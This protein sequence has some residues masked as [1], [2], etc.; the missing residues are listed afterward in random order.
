LSEAADSRMVFIRGGHSLEQQAPLE[1][2]A[3]DRMA[4]AWMSR[5]VGGDAPET[6]PEAWSE[7]PGD[8]GGSTDG[9]TRRS[10]DIPEVTYWR[11]QDGAFATADALPDAAAG[12]ARTLA[13]STTA[14]GGTTDLVGG[15]APGSSSEV[16]FPR[17]DDYAPGTF[18]D[19][20]YPVEAETEL[21]GV[22][23]LSLTVT[24]L[25]S[26]PRVFAK[27]YHVGSDGSAELIYNQATAYEIEGAV[28]EPNE[29]AVELAGIERRFE[30]DDT[31]RVTISTT[32]VAYLNSR[33]SAGV[34][35]D[36]DASEIHLPIRGESGLA[37]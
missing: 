1:Q 29:I 19:F 11:G 16:V 5:H 34:R 4:L 28:G 18:A 27:L 17:N 6:L 25:G 23:E 20:D 14:S 15:P 36:N 7:S 13:S 37:D 24:P 31:L 8:R 22:P 26:E 2:A 35:I 21:L 33:R 10:P 12:P 3:I 32:D 30:A 9:S